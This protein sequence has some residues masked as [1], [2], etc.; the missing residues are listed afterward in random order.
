[1]STSVHWSKDV[2]LDRNELSDVCM[3]APNDIVKL[4]SVHDVFEGDACNV[5][6]SDHIKECYGP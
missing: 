5:N 4:S 6:R 1:M 2:M 3:L